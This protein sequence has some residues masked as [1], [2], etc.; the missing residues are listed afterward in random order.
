[1]ERRRST[2]DA[3]VIREVWDG[4]V[5]EARPCIVVEDRVDQ[6]TLFVPRGASGAVPVDEGGARLHVPSGV[7]R[8]SRRPTTSAVLSFAWPEVPYAVLLIWSP[9]DKRPRWYVN[10]QAPLARTTL[11]FDTTDHVLDVLITSDRSGWRWKDEEE[12]AEVVSLGLFSPEE[13]AGFRT[14]SERAVEHVLLRRPPFDVEWDGWLPDPA[15]PTPELPAG[16]DER[17]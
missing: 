2:G 17:R 11:G 5:F 16:W 7:W 10:L 13:A 9:N 14:W 1:M 3:A 8:W 4:R 15:W 12:L 6:T